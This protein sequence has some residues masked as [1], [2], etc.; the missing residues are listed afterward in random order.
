VRL[1][2]RVLLAYLN[3]TL[4]PGAAKVL[5]PKIE[6]SAA[7]RQ[8][9]GRIQQVISRRDLTIPLSHDP[10][11]AVDPNTIAEF[12]DG[13]L[14]SERSVEIEE[15]CLASNRYLA[16]AASCHQILGLAR[17]V[18]PS[19]DRATYQRMYG[20]VKETPAAEPSQPLKSRDIRARYKG[21]IVRRQ[22]LAAA[23]GILILL[24]ALV[25]G[26]YYFGIFR[27]ILPRDEIASA[28]NFPGKIPSDVDKVP[29]ARVKTNA[30]A[31]LP[32]AAKSA[33][34]PQSKKE[35]VVIGRLISLQGVP[36]VVLQT[37]D[38]NQT[39]KVLPPECPA[40]SG[41]RL[42]CLPGFSS[43][44]NLKTGLRL[45]LQGNLPD[46]S[47]FVESAVALQDSPGLD[48][49]VVL[50]RG[51]ATIANHKPGA[52]VR[53]RFLDEAWDLELKEPETEVAMELWSVYPP[54]NPPS[55]PS[56]RWGREGW[57]AEEPMAGLNLFVLKGNARLKIRYDL[58]DLEGPPGQCLFTWNNIGS[59]SRQAKSL[60]Q[61]PSWTSFPPSLAEEVRQ[62]LEDLRKGLEAKG[63]I[64]IALVNTLH[65][66]DHFKR[67]SGIFGL[68]AVD[69]LSPLF[70]VWGDAKQPA[71]I[72]LSATAALKHWMGRNSGQG[73]R[74]Y[75]ALE[76]KYS[77]ETAESLMIL[78]HGFS[79]KQAQEP[80]TYHSLIDWLRHQELPVREL[81]FSQLFALVPEGRTI[82][83]DPAGNMAQRD[84]AFQEWKKL[85][86]EGQLPPNKR[87]KEG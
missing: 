84:R 73:T 61:A 43:E 57:G 38:E 52:H 45:R 17:Q 69:S 7:A 44:L 34:N 80:A 19:P 14:T 35:P 27:S 56:P 41:D 9:I 20:L 10:G 87:K 51:R 36:N 30:E 39:W 22:L 42:L 74:L 63:A 53:V 18:T 1:E 76:K 78:L 68:G 54:G 72:R 62:A 5:A 13:A 75:Q 66:P 60:R 32:P 29:K 64:E 12:L 37:P 70:E 86:P 83:Y 55:Q 16:E 2:L 3:Q 31:K 59:L 79:E 21:L 26:G 15:I 8:V 85:I 23:A 65:D 33:A 58:H 48:L 81:A 28:S 24:T 6:R 46:G 40:Y 4:E 11:Q 67:V 71:G 25:A 49:D 50:L 82:P 77:P 47:P